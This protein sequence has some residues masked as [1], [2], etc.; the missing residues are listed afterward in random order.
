MAS[1]ASSLF[2]KL[3]AFLR[4]EF[5]EIGGG[6]GINIHGDYVGVRV[7]RGWGSVLGLGGVIGTVLLVAALCVGEP[8]VVFFFGSSDFGAR[9]CFPFVHS[10]RNLIPIQGFAVYPLAQ[11]FSEAYNG[12]FSVEG[13]TSSEGQSFEGG[14][15]SVNV[16]PCHGEFH[17]LVIRILLLGR[18]R[19]SVMEGC[20]ELGPEDFV[21]LAYMIGFGGVGMCY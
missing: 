16:P 6:S 15:I 13:P 17:E 14:N 11:A 21:I 18:V 3:R 2:C 5:L 19:P 12:P 9:C 1:E 20:F 8:C 10:M 4:S 7:G